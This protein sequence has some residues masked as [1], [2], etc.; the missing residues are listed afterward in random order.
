M[1]H[2]PELALELARSGSFD[3]VCFGHDH[4]FRVEQEAGL[5][6]NPG[7]LLGWD[8]STR[9]DVP[10]TFAVLDTDTREPSFFEVVGGEVRPLVDVDRRS[11]I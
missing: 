8:P 3:L 1:N 4:R 2:F 9:A 11:I 10:A 5:A 6:L 7:T